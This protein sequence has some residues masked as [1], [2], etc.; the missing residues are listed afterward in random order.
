MTST[1]ISASLVL[2]EEFGDEDVHTFS[3]AELGIEPEADEIEW[4]Q[5]NT[6]KFQ[7]AAQRLKEKIKGTSLET[8]FAGTSL[9]HELE[10]LQESPSG[11]KKDEDAHKVIRKIRPQK[12][13]VREKL[14]IRYSDEKVLTCYITPEQLLVLIEKTHPTAVQFCSIS[15]DWHL[16]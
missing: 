7:A 3:D 2:L 13:I 6:N 9:L 15:E 10:N 12:K 11:I 1:P 14:R 8:Y 5:E 4:L 16:I